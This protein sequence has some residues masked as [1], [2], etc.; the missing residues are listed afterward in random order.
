L[1]ISLQTSEFIITFSVSD[2]PTQP[3]FNG[4]NLF[5]DVE[6]VIQWLN[7]CPETVSLVDQTMRHT[8]STICTVKK[9]GLLQ[10]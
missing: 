1:S 9:Y 8:K 7:K 5:D 2:L 3:S 10:H 4:L 6:T